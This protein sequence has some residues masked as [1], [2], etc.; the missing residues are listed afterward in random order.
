MLYTVSNL[1]LSKP[2]FLILVVYYCPTAYFLLLLYLGQITNE[3]SLFTYAPNESV[4]TFANASF[5]PMF[6]ENI[7]WVDNAT[8]DAAFSACDGDVACLFDAASTN[9]VSIGTNSKDVNIQL[10]KENEELG[11][12]IPGGFC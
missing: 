4:A 5:E 10:V 12:P 3:E 8:R 9:D 1:V 7:E 2:P 6:V 11:K